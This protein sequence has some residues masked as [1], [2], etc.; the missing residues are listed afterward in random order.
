MFCQSPFH[1]GEFGSSVALSLCLFG[2]H[3]QLPSLLA[4]PKGGFRVLIQPWLTPEALEY[5]ELARANREIFAETV[6]YL[7][8]D[9]DTMGTSKPNKNTP[10]WMICDDWQ[11]VAQVEHGSDDDAKEGDDNDAKEGDDDDKNDFDDL[12]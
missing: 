6:H 5:Q 3:L 2:T 9:D 10:A 11:L 4:D 8:D 1:T 7:D 12:L